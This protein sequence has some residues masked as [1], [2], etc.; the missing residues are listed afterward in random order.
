[1]IWVV[2]GLAYLVAAI[3]F[4]SVS[5]RTAQAESQLMVVESTNIESKAA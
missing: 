2:L 4:Y 1:M 5:M 3:S